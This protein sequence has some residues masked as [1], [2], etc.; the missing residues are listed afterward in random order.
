VGPRAPPGVLPE[1]GKIHAETPQGCADRKGP[2][3]QVLVNE[4]VTVCKHRN[5]LLLD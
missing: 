2:D 5:I 4:T 3:D 1:V